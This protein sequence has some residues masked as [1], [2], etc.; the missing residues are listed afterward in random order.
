VIIIT[1]ESAAITHVGLVRTNNEDNYYINGKFKRDNNIPTE[2]YSDTSNRD[3]GIYAVCDGMG[4]ENYGELASMIAVAVLAEYQDT[5]LRESIYDYV[6]RAN[7]IICGEIKKNGARSGTTI[8]MLYIDGNKAVS[9]N[10]GD[11]RVYFLRKDELY[12]VS[13]DH[14]EAQEMVKR[15]LITDEEAKTHKSKHKLTQHLGVFPEENNVEPYISQEIKLKKN[16]M[17]LICSDGLTD[18]VGDDEIRM[19]LST[20]KTDAV[21]IAKMLSAAAQSYGG[22]DNATV[23]VVKVY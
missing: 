2:G 15:G 11:S 23:V 12:L 22:K 3:W 4:G 17:F 18:M 8:A 20:E 21:G 5:D 10:I 6:D 13:E 1:I 7:S 19:I 14:T 9:F 16:D